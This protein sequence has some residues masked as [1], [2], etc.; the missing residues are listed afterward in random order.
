VNSGTYTGDTGISRLGAGSLA[1]GNG[2][3]NDVSAKVTHGS[4]VL[5]SAAPTVAVSQVGFGGT[6]SATASVGGIVPPVTVAGYLIVNVAGTQVKVPY[7]A[8]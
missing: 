1:L 5:T 6:V 4:S 2:T 7:Y 8:N 3:V